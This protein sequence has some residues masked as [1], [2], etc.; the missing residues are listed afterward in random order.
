MPV[1]I[2]FPD[3]DPTWA[4]SVSISP[5]VLKNPYGDGYEQRIPDGLN[6]VREIWSVSFE[7]IAY[8]ECLE[9]KNF[10]KARAGAEAFNWA[11]PGETEIQVKCESF[12]VEKTSGNTGN[13]KATFE[14]V[15]DL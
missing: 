1:T 11:P 8:T 15:F 12:T 13:V 5:R 2:D 3:I 14:Q 4:T 10:L 9:I 7:G 6:T